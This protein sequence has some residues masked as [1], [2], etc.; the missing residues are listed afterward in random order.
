[1]LEQYTIADILTWLDEKTLVVN[2]DYQRSDRVWPQAA[3]AYLIDTILRDL[4]IPRIYV[5]TDTDP[6]TWKS[7]REI[8]DGQQRISAIKSYVNDELPLGSNTEVF[9]DYANKRFS[10]LEPETQK[11]FLQYQVP[12]EQLFNASDPE[13][14]D[15]FRRL[16][17]HSYS[18][19]R[20]ELRHGKYQGRF[21]N[22]V[23]GT[24]KNWSVLWDTYKVTTTRARVRMADDEL[25]AQMYGVILEGV[26]DGGQPKIDKLYK[27]YDDFLPS[28]AS[29]DVE[30]T[31]KFIISKMAP[32]METGLA[33]APH[34]LML[35]AAVAHA[36]I[37]IPDGDMG[38]ELPLKDGKALHDIPAAAANLSTVAAVLDLEPDEVPQ[39][40]AEFKTA[41]TATTHRI[42][43]R[44]VRFQ[45]IYK[46][47]LPDPI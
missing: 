39:R 32:V 18:L 5:R 12:C 36:R 1:M 24:S 43:S 40:F 37:G 31:L 44:R 3:K 6:T 14:F 29:R 45:I 41:S 34:F 15:I 19:T 10:D 23:L 9:G 8:V 2:R 11:Q 13:V 4:P 25:T 33:G 21:R 22:A 35:F 27:Q 17:V 7:Y 26:C 20:Q 46:A 42:R 47:L 30:M 16:N 38:S 28:R